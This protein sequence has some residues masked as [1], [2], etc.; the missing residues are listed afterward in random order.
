MASRP[1]DHEGAPYED[2][3]R[4]YQGRPH[5]TSIVRQNFKVRLRSR[6]RF[7]FVFFSLAF[8]SDF[9]VL[10]R[11]RRRS[12]AKRRLR[13]M[14]LRRTGDSNAVAARTV[15]HLW[16]KARAVTSTTRNAAHAGLRSRRPVT[17]YSLACTTATAGSRPRISCRTGTMICSKG[18]CPICPPR[19]EQCVAPVAPRLD[20]GHRRLLAASWRPTAWMCRKRSKRRARRSSHAPCASLFVALAVS[21]HA[22]PAKFACA[23]D[24]AALTPFAPTCVVL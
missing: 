23:Q 21:G 6:L 16:A 15:P 22:P 5:L 7:A 9:A 3:T 8:A 10:L 2:P 14:I 24:H 17:T 4:R 11:A 19:H 13:P 20:G 12:S 18:G 1:W